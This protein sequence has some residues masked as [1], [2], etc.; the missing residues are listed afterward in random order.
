MRRILKLRTLKVLLAGAFISLLWASPALAHG[1]LDSS[2]PAPAEVMQSAPK[3]IILYFNEAVTPVARSIEMYNEDGQRIVVGEA[4][5]SPEDPAVLI[6]GGVPNIPDGLYVVAW[7]ALSDDGHAIDGAYT[8]QI[9]SAEGVLA[10]QDL[11]NNVLSGQSGPAGLSWVMGIARFAGFAGLCL[12]L[13]CLAMMVGGGIRSRRLSK[14]VGLGWVLSFASTVT[15]FVT[16]GPYAIAGKWS[17]VWSTSLWSDVLDTRQGRAILIREILLLGILGLLIALRKNFH[18]SATSWWRST[19]VLL[20]AGVVLTF[21]AAGHPS[22]SSSSNL[23]IA[24]DAVHFASVILWTGGLVAMAFLAK[25]TDFAEVVRKFSKMATIAIPLAVLSGLWQTWH[26][27]PAL[28]DITETT[29]GKT[30]VVKTTIAIAVVTLG[31]VARWLIHR[32]HSVS[33]RRVLLLE[34]GLVAII[35]GVTSS[36]VAASPEVTAPDSV[37]LVQAVNGDTI[38]NI[39]VTPG[40]TGNNEIH[41]TISTPSGALDPVQNITMRLTLPDSEVPTIAVPVTEIAPNHFSGSVGILFPGLWTLEIFLEPDSQS[42]IRLST[43]IQ[44]PG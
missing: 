39:A 21:S 40:R 20:G 5:V 19:A 9:G 29:W 35:F 14:V 15:L 6:A 44:I 18:R 31:G 7:R 1:E 36:L 26:L 23:A 24:I 30:L 25:K 12:L 28:S 22:A 27:V 43:N 10:T 13:G 8:F 34:L 42:S 11:I 4:L 33:I 41:V 17:D 38:S 2:S 16:Q 32:G 3:E 37:Y